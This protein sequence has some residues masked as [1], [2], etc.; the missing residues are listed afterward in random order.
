MFLCIQA[1]NA[2]WNPYYYDRRRRTLTKKLVFKDI[3][4]LRTELRSLVYLALMTNRSIIVPNLL[5]PDKILPSLRQYNK[6]ILWPGFRVAKVLPNEM[7]QI[8]ILEPAFYYRVQRDYLSDGDELAEPSIIRFNITSDLKK[9]LRLGQV[10]KELQSPEFDSKPRVVLD[11]IF[12]PLET[13]SK[14]MAMESLPSIL[15]WALDSVGVYGSY[16]AELSLYFPLPMMNV[17]LNIFQRGIV[18]NVRT[19]ASIFQE[20]KGNRSCFDKCR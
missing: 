1:V 12:N 20:P 17:P 14:S 18:K 7:F 10:L 8:N 5:G 16:E 15:E 13:S 19:C 4:T 9:N 2:F 6:K 11:F 3:H